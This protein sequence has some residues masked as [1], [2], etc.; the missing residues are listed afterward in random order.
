[1]KKRK[2]GKKCIALAL[3]ALVAFALP[4]AAAEP[5]KVY[6]GANAVWFD[7]PIGGPSDFELG[8]TARASL[9]P[10][11][12]LVGSGWYGVQENYLRATAGF[13]VTATDVDN[14]D[15]SVGFGLQYLVC[16]DED[17]RPTEWQGETSI[18]WKPGMGP[19]VL[20]AQAFYGMKSNQAG[21]LVAARY[22]LFTVGGAR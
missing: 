7:S 6:G 2:G 21:L 16:D 14:S 5:I 13:R 22:P 8:A 10:H 9:Q 19:L 12:S 15:F 20:G 11:L 3:A 1:M 17:I 18:G 4:A